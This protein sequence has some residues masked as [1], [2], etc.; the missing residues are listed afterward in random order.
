MRRTQKTI[1]LAAT[2]GNSPPA[3]AVANNANLLNI[4]Q[5]AS[6]LAVS[7]KTIRRMVRART[8][9]AIYVG[10]QIRFRPHSIQRFLDERE[11]GGFI[12]PR[13]GR[14]RGSVRM[15]S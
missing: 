11:V 13:R 6:F 12:P 4:S 8:L 3:R 7:E 2:S 9:P 15:K 5:L 1:D 10:N 14:P